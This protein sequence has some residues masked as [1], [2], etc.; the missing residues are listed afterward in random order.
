MCVLSTLCAVPATCMC[1]CVLPVTVAFVYFS[2]WTQMAG[3]LFEKIIY[4]KNWLQC[5][6]SVFPVKIWLAGGIQ[7]SGQTNLVFKHLNVL[8]DWATLSSQEKTNK[9]QSANRNVIAFYNFK[10]VWSISIWSK[11]NR[12]CLTWAI[13]ILRNYQSR[14]S[15]T[16]TNIRKNITPDR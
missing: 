11:W 5:K 7:T 6:A 4:L 14:S 3:V 12:E 2:Q 1:Q 8:V 16:E 13:H 9:A 15:E 10:P